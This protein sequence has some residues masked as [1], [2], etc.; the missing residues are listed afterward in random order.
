MKTKNNVFSAKYLQTQKEKEAVM[1]PE[2]LMDPN[3]SRKTYPYICTVS[4]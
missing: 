4:W 1:I 2:V 3:L